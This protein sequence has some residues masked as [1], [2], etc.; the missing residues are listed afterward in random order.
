MTIH[1]RAKRLPPILV[2]LEALGAYHH[3]KR[4]VA[5]KLVTACHDIHIRT[6]TDV[7]ASV[8]A[9]GEKLPIVAVDVKA[10][11]IQ[12][13]SADEVLRIG[14]SDRLHKKRLLYVHF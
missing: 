7:D 4:V 12:H 2:M 5:D 8:V 1:H 13:P 14:R 9:V 6:L 10:S 11:N 3:I